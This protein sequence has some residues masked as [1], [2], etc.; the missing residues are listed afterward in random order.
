MGQFAERVHTRQEEIAQIESRAV[1]LD[2]ETWV[3]LTLEDGT[4]V[5][6]VVAVRPTVQTFRD[7]EGR[8]GINAL[9]RIDDASDEAVTHYIWLDS[10]REIR[11]L[12]SS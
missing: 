5:E 6:G 9:V 11:H 2:G 8:E 12:G 4:V 7:P 10:I 1:Q 3:A